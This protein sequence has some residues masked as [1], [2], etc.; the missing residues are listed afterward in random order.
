M[1]GA[2][3]ALKVTLLMLVTTLASLA[4]DPDELLRALAPALVSLGAHRLAG[5]AHGAAARRRR[6]AARR[7]AAH[8]PDGARARRARPG[9]AARAVVGGSLERAMD[10][11]ATLELR[12]FAVRARRGAR[13]VRRPWSRHDL[14]F[15]ALRRCRARAGAS[16]GGSRGAGRVRRPTRWCTL[17]LGAGTFVLCAA[18]VARG[19]AAVRRPAG[20]RADDRAAAVASTGVTYRYPGAET[21]RWTT[22]A[23]RS[24]PA[25]S[26]C[27]PGSPATASRRCCARRAASCRTSTAARSPAR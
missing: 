11:A 15:L 27:S 25:S 20:D 23:S 24:S 10:V 1:Y 26:A 2:V 9:R 5:H 7:G 4:V 18:L 21:P 13:A 3:I 14:A 6:A 8:A 17:P 16:G 22:S 12:G 19:A